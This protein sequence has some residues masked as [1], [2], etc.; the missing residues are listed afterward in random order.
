MSVKIVEGKRER[1][2]FIWKLE[3][4]PRARQKTQESRIVE[5]FPA[6]GLQKMEIAAPHSGGIRAKPACPQRET[7]VK[8]AQSQPIAQFALPSIAD[9]RCAPIVRFPDKIAQIVAQ[10]ESVVLDNQTVR[11]GE[12]S[13]KPLNAVGGHGVDISRNERGFDLQFD[14]RFR[15]CKGQ[16]FR[17]GAVHYKDGFKPSQEMPSLADGALDP[18]KGLRRGV[19]RRKGIDDKRDVLFIFGRH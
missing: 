2:F 4:E 18:L 1:G 14:G 10:R 12:S 16:G 13:M 11:S 9:Y 6:F 3:R 7:A 17:E 8:R 5:V 15:P 19:F